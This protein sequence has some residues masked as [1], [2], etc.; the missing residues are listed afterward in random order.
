MFS[1]STSSKE[2]EYRRLTGD[3]R[4]IGVAKNA[5]IDALNQVKDAVGIEERTVAVTRTSGGLLY[6]PF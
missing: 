5:S 3:A 1:E 2:G 4:V 6:I